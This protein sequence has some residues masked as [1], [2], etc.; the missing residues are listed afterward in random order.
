MIKRLLLFCLLVSFAT[1]NNSMNLLKDLKEKK[2]GLEYLYYQNRNLLYFNGISICVA[3]AFLTHCS[4][5]IISNP[6]I[7]LTCDAF[8]AAGLL[9]ALACDGVRDKRERQNEKNYYLTVAANNGRLDTMHWLYANGA[10]INEELVDD[11]RYGVSKKNLICPLYA[12]LSENQ[13]DAASF[14]NNH[15]A[16]INIKIGKNQET[17]LMLLARAQRT[18]DI[19]AGMQ[20]LL[21]E[22]A[23]LNQEDALGR[24]ALDMATTT[25][26][27]LLLLEAQQNSPLR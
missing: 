17:I 14:L 7:A 16:D 26:R 9:Y 4:H 11:S 19:N 12:A 8:C 22:G 24:T 2:G 18:M 5:N 20:W 13:I 3:L 23:N 1:N 15:G 21:Q 10:Q 6:T 25:Q 27:K